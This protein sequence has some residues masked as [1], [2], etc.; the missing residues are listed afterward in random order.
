MPKKCQ[1]KEIE[2][3]EK[4]QTWRP[5][6]L[7]FCTVHSDDELQTLPQKQEPLPTMTVGG[8]RWLTPPIRSSGG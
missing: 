6:I 2:G 3:E 8:V 5:N 4:G 7:F 1:R